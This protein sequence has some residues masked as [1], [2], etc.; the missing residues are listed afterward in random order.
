M[1]PPGRKPKADSSFVEA[2]SELAAFLKERRRVMGMT[3]QAL[4]NEA[5]V[6]ESWLA[7]LEQGVILEPGLF[8]TLAV[9]RVL[10]VKMPKLG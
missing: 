5:G 3:Q 1:A 4:A 8:P 2:A 10:G 7:K 9:L 6:S